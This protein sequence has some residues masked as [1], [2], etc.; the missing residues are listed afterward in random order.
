M[1]SGESAVVASGARRV[2]IQLI[3]VAML[4]AAPL[5]KSI[6]ADSWSPE[7][8]NKHK[9]KGAEVDTCASGT[10]TPM[11]MPPVG[12]P[13]DLEVTGPCVVPAGNYY[14]GNVNI[15]KKKGATAGGILS[16]NDATIDFWANSILVENAGT[17][18]AGVAAD[19]KTVQPIGTANIL[20]TLTI[21]L[22]GAE[23][24]DPKNGSGITC[25]TD[26]GEPDGNECGV[27]QPD[28]KSNIGNTSTQKCTVAQAMPGGVQDCFYAYKALNWDGA[29]PTAYFG[30]KVLALS[31]GG[32]LQL[33]GAKGASYDTTTNGD[34]SKS[35]VSWVRLGAD[36]AGTGKETT[37]TLDR[38]VSWQDGDKIVITSTD[39]M[40]AHAELLTVMGAVK[41]STTVN[42]TTA[43]QYPHKGTPYPLSTKT[44]ISSTGIDP[45]LISNGIET[46]AAVGLLTRNIRIVSGGSGPGVGFPALPCTDQK[47]GCYFGGHTIVRQGFQTYQVQ[48]VE[49]YQLG[50]GGKIGHYPVHFHLARKTGRTDPTQNAFVKD[51]SIWDSMTRWIVIHGTQDV[52]LARNVGYESIGHGYYLEDATEINNKLYS[53][54][55]ILA[56]AAVDNVLNPRKVPGIL[57]ADFS[58]IA[59]VPPANQVPQEFVPYHSDIDHPSVFWMTNG[60]NDFRYNMAAG[61]GTCG[62]CYWLVPSAIS[63]PS[64]SMAWDS[65]A[66]EQTSPD[67]LETSPLE[68]FYGNYCSTAMTSFQTIGNS[69]PCLGI[70]RNDP[71]NSQFPILPAIHNDLATQLP[72]MQ[73]ADPKKP[74]FTPDQIKVLQQYYPIVDAG[75]GRKATKCPDVDPTKP[76][77]P[78][79]DC[80]DDQVAPVC[81]SGNESNCMVTILDHYTSSYNWAHFNLSAIWLRPQW[82]L[83]INSV[84]TDIQSGGLTFVTGGGYTESDA[85]PGHWALALKDIFVGATQPTN[86][87]ALEGGP[88]NPTTAGFEGP[89]PPTT[90]YGKKISCAL[91]TNG[92]DPGYCLD[93]IQ[94]VSFPPSNFGGNQ[95]FFNIYDGPSYEDSNAYLDINKTSNLDCNA[96]TGCGTGH[97]QWFNA[98][99]LGTPRDNTVSGANNCYLPNAAI[100]WKQPNGFYY[101]PA[102][103]SKNLFF[104]NVDIRHYVIEPLFNAGTFQ[105]NPTAIANHYCTTNSAMFDNFTDVDRQTELND[106]DGSLTGLVDTISVNLD[107]FFSAPVETVECES[108]PFIDDTVT[109]VLPPG[110]AKTSPYDYVTTAIYPKCMAAM[111][112]QDQCNKL[113]K[114]SDPPMVDPKTIWNTGCSTETCY[115]VPLYRQDLTQQEKNGPPMP[116][117]I[118]TPSIRL[119]GQDQAQRSSLTVNNATYY[120]DTTLDA[121]GQTAPPRA[122]VSNVFEAGNTYYTYFLF[123]K[124]TTKQTYQLYVGKDTAWNPDT[125]VK[126]VRVALPSFPYQFTEEMTWPTTWKRD[127]DGTGN[128]YDPT[129]GIETITVDMNGYADFLTDFNLS[130]SNECAPTTFC[131]PVGESPNTT[132][133]CQ[134][135]NTD[136][137]FNDCQSICTNWAN[138]DVACPDGKC[139]GFAVTLSDQFDTIPKSQPRP[140]P[141]PGCFPND[142]FNIPVTPAAPELAGSCAN[143]LLPITQS[144][145]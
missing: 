42:V 2:L 86:A 145:N 98:K 84:L 20:N 8:K 30:Y 1:G 34:P 105:T 3:M 100:A 120:I 68:T 29:I 57:A 7:N 27:D 140:Q 106:D 101:P 65:Y 55:G 28:W 134:L 122:S 63:G 78:A 64:R 26:P 143:P 14:Y 77:A 114:N 71:N 92:Q 6:S 25:K 13:L 94:S 33:F 93:P 129:T 138:K 104:D 39:Y 54:L 48:G 88:F 75:G 132:C 12:N 46:Q 107:P 91:A 67:R 18:R 76:F 82:Y 47:L 131:K 142:V 90:P 97:T 96:T 10:L 5:V 49:F 31:W 95:R 19:G 112:G 74:P 16:F 9:L 110:T 50:Q 36:L 119:M 35:G 40:P 72:T 79:T 99:Q 133:T 73:N 44:G 38:P 125:N 62:V 109:P 24:A 51:S 70:V 59:G 81:S 116:S 127:T 128:G 22:W 69:S 108:G 103:H 11:M 121:A 102:F 144:C 115:G 117:A 37:I 141:T 56:R 113:I 53:N 4:I 41:N 61:A 15:F 126:M 124:P 85:I 80:S 118:P 17:L 139:F 111:P 32:S 130:K 60:W 66:A 87:Y 135:S 136:P 43:V 21:H 58:P 23:S 52:T 89:N 137:L 123:A 45:T 83:V